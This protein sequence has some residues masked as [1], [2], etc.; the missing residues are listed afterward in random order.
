MTAA[1]T[2]TLVRDVASPETTIPG[3][4]DVTSGVEDT[5]AT[6]P[7]DNTSPGTLERPAYLMNCPFS[8]S[9]NEPKNAWMRELDDS[10]R[11]IDRTAA[12]RQFAQL[13]DYMATDAFVFLLPT[14]ADCQLQDLVFTANLG[15]VL[16]HFPQRDIV[17]LSNFASEPRIGETEVGHGFFRAM[18]YTTVVAPYKFEGE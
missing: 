16:E 5:V 3:L 9:A 15:I 12:M 6:A 4:S 1:S 2:E 8:F 13:Y 7:R 14:P 10:A 18:G 11:T 17:V